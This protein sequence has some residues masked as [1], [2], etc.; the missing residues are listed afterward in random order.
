MR[1]PTTARTAGAFAAA[2]VLIGGV[3]AQA[4]PVL[5]SAQIHIVVSSPTTC[6][7]SMRLSIDGATDVE[8]RIEAF[9][10]SQIDLVGVT[11]ATRVGE[12]TT[13]GRTRS[14]VV[15]P[16]ASSYEIRYTA[17]Q[18]HDR[19]ER[20]PLWL[21]TV[22]TDGRSRA[23]EIVVQLPDATTP[24]PSMPSF[25]WTRTSGL[26]TLAHVP[27]FVRVPYMH[28]G[29]TPGWDLTTVIDW[30]TVGTFAVATVL[31]FWRRRPTAWA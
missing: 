3:I 17:Q 31:W 16:G 5:R 19:R 20:C 4:A 15:R 24:R 30:I 11:D 2:Y 21:P 23:V 14:L 22:P 26:T 13:K 9:E 6:A 8:H 29:E 28:D 18:A 1:L 10:G 27:A 25:T 12:P 7:V